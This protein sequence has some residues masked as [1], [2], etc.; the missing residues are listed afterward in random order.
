MVIQYEGFPERLLLKV[1]G[2]ARENQVFWINLLI[3]R[4]TA[5]NLSCH[6]CPDCWSNRSALSFAM[7]PVHPLSESITGV[8]ASIFVAQNWVEFPSASNDWHRTNFAGRF[9]DYSDWTNFETFHSPIHEISNQPCIAWETISFIFCSH[10]NHCTRGS[11]MRSRKVRLRWD[12]EVRAKAAEWE[13]SLECRRRMEGKDSRKLIVV[14]SMSY[15]GYPYRRWWSC[16]PIC[17]LV[18]VCIYRTVRVKIRFVSPRPGQWREYQQSGAV[19][20]KINA[21]VG[22]NQI[23]LNF[24]ARV[25]EKQKPN[26][27]NLQLN[28]CATPFLSTPNNLYS[29]VGT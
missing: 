25:C 9:V 7:Y 27:Q 2:D 8:V 18:V 21:I 1:E 16:V 11:S 23:K 5:R 12:W 24:R 13:W 26:L 28:R 6:L 19:P 17:I 10:K 29:S 20:I 22:N 15:H 3:L 14:S 4:T